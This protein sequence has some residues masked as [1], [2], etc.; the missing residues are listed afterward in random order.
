MPFIHLKLSSLD[1][2]LNAA[3]QGLCADARE[4]IT[5]E[6]ASHYD[7]ALTEARREGLSEAG[8][9][10]KAVRLLG[11]PRCAQRRLRREHLT[12]R[13]SKAV[14]RMVGEYD[15]LLKSY[16]DNWKPPSVL[17]ITL[18]FLIVSMGF[19]FFFLLMFISD[20][21]GFPTF[22]DPA[23]FI[24]VGMAIVMPLIMLGI[25]I[26]ASYRNHPSMALWCRP[27]RS[28]LGNGL[29]F[30]CMAMLLMGGFV[31]RLWTDRYYDLPVVAGDEKLINVL[32]FINSSIRLPFQYDS[33]FVFVDALLLIMALKALVSGSR[34]W[35]LA[36]KLHRLGYTDTPSA[37]S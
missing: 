31:F 27:L 5:E 12:I 16:D 4:R 2:W 3:T 14:E 26:E 30:L 21:D 22:D 34:S 18:F 13:E 24:T 37:Y 9:T 1:D 20:G 10:A 15:S 6:I 35:L 36:T 17:R 32:P 8:A 28:A 25:H 33:N 11:N 29:L 19:T 7:E 23:L